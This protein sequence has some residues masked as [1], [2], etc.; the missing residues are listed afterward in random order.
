MVLIGGSDTGIIIEKILLSKWWRCINFHWKYLSEKN[1]KATLWNY[2]RN[3][4][5]ILKKYLSFFFF[6]LLCGFL[7]NEAISFHKCFDTTVFHAE[8][9]L[10]LRNWPALSLN[11]STIENLWVNLFKAYMEI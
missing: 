11:L 3:Y 8:K 5:M 7:L 9:K 1:N 2:I 4:F 6:S 10:K